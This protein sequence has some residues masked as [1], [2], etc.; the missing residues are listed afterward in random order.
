MKYK[1]LLNAKYGEIYYEAGDEIELSDPNHFLIGDGLVEAIEPVEKPIEK[2]KKQ[3]AK[4]KKR[5][6]RKRKK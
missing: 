1:F 6:I 5:I 4:P 2:S 3:V